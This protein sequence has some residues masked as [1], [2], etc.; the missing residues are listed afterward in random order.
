MT[1]RFR[2]L[3]AF[4]AA[5]LLSAGG[6]PIAAAH[7]VS[8]ELLAPLASRYMQAV[9]P[10]EEAEL[11]LELYRSVLESVQFKYVREVDVSEFVA[12]A[13]AE[14]EPLEPHAGDPA[15]VFKQ[16]INAALASLDPHSRYIDSQSHGRARSAAVRET[17]RSESLSWRMQDDVLVL[18]LSSFTGAVAAAI[19]TAVADASATRPPRG[20]VLDLRGNLGGL[21]HEAVKTADAFLGEGEIGSLEGRSYSRRT[22]QA[23]SAQLLGGVPMV[24]L[25]DQHS[26]SASEL[27]A[28][29]LQDNGRATILGQRSNGKGSVQD[30]IA[31]GSDRGVLRLTTTLYYGP[32]GRLVQRTGLGPDIELVPAPETPA[33]AGRREADRPRALPGADEPPPPKARVEQSRCANTRANTESALACALAFLDAGDIAAFLVSLEAPNADLG[34]FRQI[35]R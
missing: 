9:R 12:A 8:E 11:H 24:V 3:A 33:E 17:A 19:A 35:C 4:T 27:V 29:A 14:I 15:E 18:R 10:G 30:T 34:L 26:A 31:L 25:I 6:T 7:A 32:S 21:F 13:I 5:W 20:I 22:W 2:I 28:A 23:D 16:S 1:R